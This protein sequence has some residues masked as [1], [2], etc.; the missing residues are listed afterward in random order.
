MIINSP[1]PYSIVINHEEDWWEI[2]SPRELSGLFDFIHVFNPTIAAINA[3]LPV[4]EK[5]LA[6]GG[7]IW[8]SWPKKSSSLWVDLT[9]NGVRTVAFALELVD[10]KVCAVDKDWSALKLMRRKK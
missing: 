6:P 5:H 7:M 3:A 9:G 8:A 10:V 4:C 1:K 2:A